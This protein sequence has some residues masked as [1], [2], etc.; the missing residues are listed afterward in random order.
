M[1]LLFYQYQTSIGIVFEQKTDK[2]TEK[3]SGISEDY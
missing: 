3:Q 1:H 2:Q